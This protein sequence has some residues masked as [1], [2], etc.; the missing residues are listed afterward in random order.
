MNNHRYFK[1]NYINPDTGEIL[2]SRKRICSKFSRDIWTTF[3]NEPFNKL[4]QYVSNDVQI[5]V[6]I[7]VTFQEDEPSLPWLSD[8]QE[9]SSICALK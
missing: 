5:V 1:V 2:F 9:D 8:P 7:S 4:R 6:Q 3:L